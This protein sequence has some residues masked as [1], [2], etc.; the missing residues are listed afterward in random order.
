MAR[1]EACAHLFK[2]VIFMIY[3]LHQFHYF[4]GFYHI[5]GVKPGDVFYLHKTNR[6]V[7]IAYMKGP[8]FGGFG[9]SVISVSFWAGN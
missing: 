6:N 3:V 1:L 9:L 7:K 8:W 5:K 2:Q 4:G